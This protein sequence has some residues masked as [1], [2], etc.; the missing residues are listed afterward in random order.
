VFNFFEPNSTYCI[1][2]SIRSDKQWLYYGIGSQITIKIID[3]KSIEECKLFYDKIW[4]NINNYLSS[5]EVVKNSK[6]GYYNE[7]EFSYNP[8]KDKIE[9]V[10]ILYIKLD[11][12]NAGRAKATKNLDI[13]Q[14]KDKKINLNNHKV[15]KKLNNHNSIISKRYF[16]SSRFVF[17]NIENNIN[18]S[19]SSFN[20]ISFYLYPD[21]FILNTN[22]KFL[23]TSKNLS[24]NVEKAQKLS[25]NVEK[26]HN[27]SQFLSEISLI[28]SEN[29]NDLNK[30]QLII[31]KKWL[32]LSFTSLDPNKTLYNTRSKIILESLDQLIT[33]VNKSKIRT[34]PKFILNLIPNPDHVHITFAIMLSKFNRSTLTDID[35]KIGYSVSN[36]IYIKNF[37]KDFKN[38]SLFIEHHKLDAKI[39]FLI[40][41]LFITTFTSYLNPIF[42]REFTDEDH[43]ILK[44]NPEY[45]NAIKD[46]LI[47][48]PQSLPMVCKPLL[49]G[50]D[51]YGGN[52]LNNTEYKNSL[53]TG[54]EQHDHR[55]R[56]DNEV[57]NAVNKLNSFKFIVNNDLL[58]YIQNE[59]SFILEFIKNKKYESYLNNII[60]MDIA[61]V[62]NNIPI[63]FS[64]N[65]DW[66]GRF[67]TQSFYLD[68]QGSEFSLALLNLEK[69]QKLD[70]NGK[71][72]FYIYGANL[73]N[74]MGINKKSH[75]ERYDWVVNN[76]DKIYSMDKDFII[77]AE[78]PTNFA[79]FCLTMK[80]LKNDPN[81]IVHNP[82]FLDATC[83]GIQHFAAMV[84]DLELSKY[85][86]LISTG[87]NV[88]DFY[89]VLIP[90]INKSINDSWSDTKIKNYKFKDINLDRKLLKKVIMTKSYNVTTYGITEQLKSKLE[91]VP[92]KIEYKGKEITVYDYKVPTN[93]GYVILDLFEM[94]KLADIINNN[95]FNHFPIL[96]SI[97][98]YL[99]QLATIYIKLNIPISWCTPDG[100]QLTQRYNA[101]KIQKIKIN[102]LGAN[103]TAVLRKW[104]TNKDSRREVQAIIPNIIHSLD[105]SHLR[106]L[107][108]RWDKYI[109]PIHDCFGTHP[110][111][112]HKLAEIV[113]V[114]FVLLYS[115]TD[116][117]NTLDDRLRQSLRDFKINIII[118][119]GDK[120]VIEN[121]DARSKLKYIPLPILP[122]YGELNLQ[123]IINKGINMI[124]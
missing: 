97:Y 20:K 57:F 116:F 69:G 52:L 115:S 54:S 59:G 117:L 94:E 96:H 29:R 86:N 53:V 104:T 58:N 91:K 72:F 87:D 27:L 103:K 107:I 102:L 120:E 50:P 83:S 78:S 76:L 3:P 40:G 71:F 45:E 16:S 111:D 18:I 123:D 101:S 2:I 77:S 34:I 35:Y 47:I 13:D 9:F 99:T 10:H 110:N 79:A 28:L 30:A 63:H 68:Y 6:N 114:T 74:Y 23:H 4:L 51:K 66:R 80:K 88:N 21:P 19:K 98:N 84:L 73:Y 32:E 25:K 44:I 49:W 14:S 12:V 37:T 42:K 22:F 38:Y 112:M 75:Q 109:L 89:S 33:I 17:K 31:E 93:E 92:K 7:A 113:R 100:L 105:A 36:H 70:E 56:L 122:K 5:E 55:T 26:T 121:I 119:E 46:N 82:I 62:Y 11:D 60:A 1:F 39:F 81:Y 43:Y 61:K 65:L 106:M 95:I 118:I 85:V 8:K 24:K 67:Y 41:E 15:S 124:T 90:K 48:S 64:V 108:N